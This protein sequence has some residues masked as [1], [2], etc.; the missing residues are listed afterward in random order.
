M[1]WCASFAKVATLQA[2][3]VAMIPL[4]GCRASKSDPNAEAPPPT[5]VN[6]EG[7]DV[8]QVDHPESFPV[9]RATESVSKLQMTAIG[10]VVSNNSLS[11]A[12]VSSGAS[13]ER[14]T[15][16]RSTWIECD[17]YR[18]D[19]AGIKVGSAVEIRPNGKVTKTFTGRIAAISPASGAPLERAKLRIATRT[20]ELIPGAFVIAA[21]PA[22]RKQVR[23]ALP[24]S[25]I[26]NFRD[27]HWVY[28]PA[29]EKA[30]RRVEV[31]P[32]D[33]LPHDM[34]EIVDGIQPAESVVQNPRDLLRN[35]EP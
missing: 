20:P 26:L 30:F 10:K 16:F 11:V 24:E 18:S 6:V 13:Q 23:A 14:P 31:V 22:Y 7:F 3:I 9:V 5:Q 1:A 4:S 33:V 28:V 2:F 15:D 34:Q 29:G 32:G 17:V 35:L 25:A 27:R 8:I 21:F 19:I 12:I